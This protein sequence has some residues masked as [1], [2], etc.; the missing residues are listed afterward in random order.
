MV[1][2]LDGLH[3]P[4]VALLDEVDQ[5]ETA[6]VVAARDGDYETQIRRNEALFST[7]VEQA[8]V[9]VYVVDAGLRLQQVN[10]MAQPVFS[11]VHPLIGRDFSE[12]LRIIWPKRVADEVL[13]RF[14]HTLKTG[15][16]YQSPAFEERRKDTDVKESYEW[17]IQRVTLP[18]GEHFTAEA[19]DTFEQFLAE[20]MVR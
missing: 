12:A 8:P 17:Q 20:G 11:K 18:A 6:A 10:P 1:E 2:A 9:G 14:R 15:T 16:P 19:V 7:V 5:R 3:Q 13:E 4:D